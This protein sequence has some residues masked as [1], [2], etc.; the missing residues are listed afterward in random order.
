MHKK[1][2]DVKIGY[3]RTAGTLAVAQHK[4]TLVKSLINK[5]SFLKLT[6]SPKTRH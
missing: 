6:K 2:M 5:L 3:N 4:K 1:D